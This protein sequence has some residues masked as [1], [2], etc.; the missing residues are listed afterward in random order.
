MAWQIFLPET[1][2]ADPI[3]EALQGEASIRQVGHQRGAHRGVVADQISLRQRGVVL[4]GREDHLVQVGEAHLMAG[5]LP[6]PSAPHLVESGQI[7]L[8]RSSWGAQLLGGSLVTS[9]SAP[10]PA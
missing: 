6:V 9:R 2:L 4:S 7:V 10:G 3:W 5:H 8:V 1:L